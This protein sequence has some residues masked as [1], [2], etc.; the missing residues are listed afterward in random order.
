MLHA[1]NEK[2]RLEHKQRV[3]RKHRE[4]NHIEHHPVYFEEFLNPEDNQI[5]WKYTY[6]YFE[7]D[8]PAN[9]WAALP[10]LFSEEPYE[11]EQKKWKSDI[12]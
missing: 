10:D 4:E 6:K 2:A 12:F 11:F 5:Y 7:I 1:Q 3:L 8:R 9:N